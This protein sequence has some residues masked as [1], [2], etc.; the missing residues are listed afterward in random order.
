MR[1]FEFNHI[2]TR[3]HFG[4]PARGARHIMRAIESFERRAHRPVRGDEQRVLAVIKNI[5]QPDEALQHIIALEHRG[6]QPVEN[7]AAP[8]LGEREIVQ[9]RARR[10]A[11]RVEIDPHQ[12]LARSRDRK[13]SPG[14]F[15]IGGM[16][17]RLRFVVGE[18]RPQ[19]FA[20]V[21]ER[22]EVAKLCRLD[23]VFAVVAR[24]VER[25]DIEMVLDAGDGRLEALVDSSFYALNSPIYPSA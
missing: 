12:L 22:R 1:P 5:D 11:Q 7:H 14:H 24:T 6:L 9:M 21:V 15:D 18:D 4:E 8:T 13:Q 17:G 10:A 3:L 16:N 19:R 2:S 23:T 25:D 20:R